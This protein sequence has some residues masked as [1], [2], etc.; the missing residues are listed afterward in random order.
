MVLPWQLEREP[1][2]NPGIRLN[3]IIVHFTH[4]FVLPHHPPHLWF[5][6]L[7]HIK[8]EISLSDSEEGQLPREG[9]Q[10]GA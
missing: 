5:M 10:E 9:E 2:W 6:L 8:R 7:F 4:L 1:N 3:K